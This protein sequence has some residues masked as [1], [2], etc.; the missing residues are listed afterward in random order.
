MSF[1]YPWMLLLFVLALPVALLWIHSVQ[2]RKSRILK[3]S[4][5]TLIKNLLVGNNPSLRR[6]HFILFFAAITLLIFAISGPRIG[7]GKEKISLTGIDVIVVL[8]VSNSMNSTDIQPS[9]IERAKLAL[10][11]MINTMSNDRIGVIVFAGKAYRCLPLT[12]DHDA[13]E[14][15]IQSIHSEM[16]TIQGT[17]IGN[18]IENARKSFGD[19]DKSR[20]RAIIL[21]SDGENHEDNAT[22]AAAVAA[23]DGII[24]CTIGIGS[25][26]GSTIPEFDKKGNLVGN[27]K[28]KNGQDVITKLNE[29]ILKSI[30]VEGKGIYVHA[31][32][33]DIGVNK[34][35][36]MLQGLSKTTKETWK[37]TTYTPIFPW[38]LLASLLLFL[39]EALLPAGKRNEFNSRRS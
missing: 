14:M 34:V 11:Q 6:W 15:L 30:A 24:L 21:I 20:G 2:K 1:E 17:A 18:A 13:G 22:E 19:I 26:N 35:Y 23:E 16:I 10:E 33:A 7:G 28:D 4:E 29:N 31:S 39:I 5:S 8:D 27:K 38:L 9:R 32:N 37:Y 36:S 25:T 3:F 12:E